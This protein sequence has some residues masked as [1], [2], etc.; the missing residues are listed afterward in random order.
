MNAFFYVLFLTLLY[1]FIITNEI[2]LMLICNIVFVSFV[3]VSFF[4]FFY[5]I[6]VFRR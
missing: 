5:F 1:I 3:L 4:S 2:E 6:F